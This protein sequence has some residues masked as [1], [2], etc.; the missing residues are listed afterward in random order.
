MVSKFV[1][2]H[3]GE[4]FINPPP[5]DLAQSYN[6]S[7]SVIPLLFILSPGAD[8]MAALL[9]FAEDNGFGGEKFDA[10][11][12]GQ[13][14]VMNIKIYIKCSTYNRGLQ[15]FMSKNH[16]QVFLNVPYVTY[17]SVKFDKICIMLAKNRQLMMNYNMNYKIY[18]IFLIYKQ[19]FYWYFHENFKFDFQNSIQLYHLIL[20][21]VIVNLS[22]DIQ[23]IKMLLCVYYATKFIHEKE[24]I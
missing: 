18:I 11:S 14:Q 24:Y 21:T 13:G 4:K 7:S 3:L 20:I 6:D 1:A 22:S 16:N 12:L 17:K 2:I 5:L 15:P 23:D 9:K 19:T 8:P 10:I